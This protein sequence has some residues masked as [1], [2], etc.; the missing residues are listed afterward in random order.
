MIGMI[1]MGVIFAAGATIMLLLGISEEDGFIIGVSVFLLVIGA[2]FII[3]G[4]GMDSV[5]DRSKD[6]AKIC[7]PYQVTHKHE[8]D[9][10]YV[11]S[12]ANDNR[13]RV[14]KK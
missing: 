6:A 9:G 5:K 3:T 14:L 7:A 13:I 1:L 12:C 2:V 4:A 11:F 8:N 10:Y